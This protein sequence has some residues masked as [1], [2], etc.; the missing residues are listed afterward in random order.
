MKKAK[1]IG[2]MAI[3]TA[4]ASL[5][6]SCKQTDKQFIDSDTIAK[7]VQA[8]QAESQLP[9]ERV[10]LGVEQAAALWQETDGTKEEF[11]AFCGEYA[12]RSEQELSELFDRFCTDFE[13]LYG[14]LNLIDQQLQRPVQIVGYKPTVIDDI[15][16]GYDETAHLSDDLFA[17]KLAFVTI[18]NFPHYTLA[19]KTGHAGEWSAREWGYVRLGD[20]F[21]ERV[22][23]S[24]QQKITTACSAGETYIANYNIAMETLVNDA[25][26]TLFPP[27]KLLSHW[28]LR[29]ELKS[30]Y[31]EGAA[32][33][34][35]QKMIYEVM[36]RVIDQ[37]IPVQAIDNDAYNWNPYTNTLYRDG[38]EVK[39]T[40]EGG[41]RY[42]YMLDIFHAERA[43][44]SY[45]GN[46]YIDRHFND[47]LEIPESDVEALF[48]AVCSSPVAA[49]VGK[50][51]EAR[52]GRSLQPYDIWY[53]GFKSRSA[54]SPEQL[55]A[56]VMAKYPTAE[57]F[58]D[59][60][61]SILTRLG[62]SPEAITLV[63]NNVQVDNAV[64]SGHA[65][66]SE[67]RGGK[68]LLR[69][70]ITDNGMNYQG[71]NTAV[72]EFGHNVEQ[73]ISLHNVDN[74]FLRSVPNNAFTEALAFVFQYKDVELLGKK[75]ADSDAETLRALTL[76]WDAYEI[77]GVALVD[78]S[79]WRWMYAHPEATPTE[80]QTAVV[81][82]AKEVW[83]EYY[84][85][86]FGIRDEPVLA[87]YSHM[88][89]IPL[90]LPSY[91]LGH[92]IDFQLEEFFA[93]KTMGREVERIYSQGRL[94]PQ[95]WMQQAVGTPL[96]S[97]PLI[98]AAEKACDAVE[99]VQ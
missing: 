30:D 2:I 8:A 11:V 61:P 39:G 66:Q 92:L 35:K 94:I 13:A 44:D 60:M 23:A 38:A 19:Q 40:P 64:G 68:A 51:I 37:T 47:E 32:G 53:D 87:I 59:D 90:Y 14:H 88:I 31:A 36:K 10:S 5:M 17:N 70:R 78:M 41:E 50:I 16:A 80:L 6:A 63:H 79:V 86:V 85:P 91:P 25:G 7:A 54:I 12:C 96:S 3:L 95:Y 48:K 75:S 72:H 43:A 15:M 42:R 84:A 89:E 45:Y 9:A 98:T 22:P 33:V 57:A 99:Q 97:Q 56:E 74:Y 93:G 18:L 67:L 21:T 69:T 49:R 28:G 1:V 29:D 62:F 46:T 52:L 24:V 77:M 71:Y 76:F 55:D 34:E 82:A 58:E 26:E 65:W 81:D 73:V 20:M 83:N 4:V 27:M